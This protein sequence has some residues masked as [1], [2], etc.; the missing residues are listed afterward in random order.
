MADAAYTPA[1]AGGRDIQEVRL[2]GLNGEIQGTGYTIADNITL[3]AGIATP[4]VA[5]IQRADY[6]IDV[7]G[8]FTAGASLTL[9]VLG[10]DKT[11]WRNI[12]TG[13]VAS[14][15][16]ANT[17]RIAANATIRFK[18]EGTQPVSALYITMG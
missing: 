10:S 3:N 4:P 13:I 5:G 9:Q 17:Y 2:R 6:I 14:G 15:I 11:T 12:T 16:V 18:N 8:T 1:E 7:Q